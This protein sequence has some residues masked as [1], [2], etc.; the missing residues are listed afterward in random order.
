MGLV[1]KSMAA[2]VWTNAPANLNNAGIIRWYNTQGSNLAVAA[3]ANAAAMTNAAGNVATNAITS[4]PIVGQIATNVVNGMWD[5]TFKPK[6]DSGVTISANG[7][8]IGQIG[9]A[10]NTG[11]PLIFFWNGTAW[12]AITFTP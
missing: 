5:N 9:V 11:S 10:D 7:D 1:A 6:V 12:K 2:F 8:Y 4:S 3:N